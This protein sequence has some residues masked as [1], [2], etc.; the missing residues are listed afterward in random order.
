MS[1]PGI[2]SLEVGGGGA[3]ISS[4]LMDEVTLS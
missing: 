1:K 3:A 2:L 4:M